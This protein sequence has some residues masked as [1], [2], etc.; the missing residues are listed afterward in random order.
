MHNIDMPLKIAHGKLLITMGAG[1]LDPFM[2]FPHVSTEVVHAHVLLT[3]WT[4][5]L[6]SQMNA[7]NMA[8]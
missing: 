6:L 2:D 3:I 5:R 7:L 4:V 8:V 1:F